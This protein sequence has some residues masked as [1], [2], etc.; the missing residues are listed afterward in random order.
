MKKIFVLLVA[1]IGF[2][3]SV[4]ATDG[5][6]PQVNIRNDATK[7]KVSVEFENSNSYK[8][9]VTFVISYK[10][11]TVSDEQYATLYANGGYCDRGYCPKWIS[12]WAG[13][14]ADFNP[15]YLSVKILKVTPLN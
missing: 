11:E 9:S 7:T 6:S 10:G 2:G 15:S 1:L 4:H 3:I 8:V 13:E 12:H 5:V 14:K